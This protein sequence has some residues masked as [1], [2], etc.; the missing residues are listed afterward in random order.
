LITHTNVLKPSHQTISITKLQTDSHETNGRYII[1]RKN[2]STRSDFIRYKNN[3]MVNGIEIT[4]T[5]NNDNGNNNND[6]RPIRHQLGSVSKSNRRKRQMDEIGSSGS[7]SISISSEQ[8]VAPPLP[9]PKRL[10]RAK[11]QYPQKQIQ[12]QQQQQQ[13]QEQH[14]EDP[15]WMRIQ[16]G[17]N[18]DFDGSCCDD[19][20]NDRSTSMISISIDAI[21]G[22]SEKERSMGYVAI[23]A[24]DLGSSSSRTA[25]TTIMPWDFY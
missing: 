13:Q 11:K 10:C 22:E 3:T 23:K 16:I 20:W 7:G 1:K 17:D 5:S 21:D 14:E 9:P 19:R 6:S 15:W 8:M 18:D 4:P 25:R 12:Q 24:C 2:N